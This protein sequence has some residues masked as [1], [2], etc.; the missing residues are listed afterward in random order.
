MQQ[1]FIKKVNYFSRAAIPKHFGL[2]T[3]LQIIEDTRE[4][5]FMWVISTD[6]YQV[7]N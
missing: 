7:R 4:L 2:K 6:I 1:K 5:W 3:L